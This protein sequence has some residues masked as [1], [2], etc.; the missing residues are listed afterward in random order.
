MPAGCGVPESPLANFCSVCGGARCGVPR[1]LTAAAR[2]ARPIKRICSVRGEGRCEVSRGVSG[3]GTPASRFWQRARQGGARGCPQCA[4]CRKRKGYGDARCAPARQGWAGAAG[5]YKKNPQRYRAGGPG[6]PR[7]PGRRPPH[8][9]GGT[10]G[11]FSHERTTIIRYVV[12]KKAAKLSRQL[13]YKANPARPI[14]KKSTCAAG[15][16][17]GTPAK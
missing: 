7:T 5:A 9:N 10:F 12:K 17:S 16:G 2:P 1:E 8:R 13:T 15:R 4:G 11:S 6:V 3:A 14:K